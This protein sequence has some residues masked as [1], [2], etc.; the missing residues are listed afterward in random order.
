LPSSR[1]VTGEYSWASSNI[2][3]SSG[4]AL[5]HKGSTSGRDWQLC[6]L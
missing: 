1:W 3:P 2:C 4:G 6:A 5:R